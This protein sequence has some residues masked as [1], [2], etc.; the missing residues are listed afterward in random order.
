[1]QLTHLKRDSNM[2]MMVMM[3]MMMMKKGRMQCAPTIIAKK[4][5]CSVPPEIRSPFHLR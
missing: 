4:G 5:A 3:M 1:M 2:V